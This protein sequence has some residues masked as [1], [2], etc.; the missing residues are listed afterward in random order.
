MRWIPSPL[1]GLGAA[2]ATA[3]ARAEL[4][5]TYARTLQATLV[6]RR[7][8]RSGEIGDPLSPAA[9]ARVA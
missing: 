3:N 8:N 2:G 4:D 5:S 7:V 6:V 9:E 1:L